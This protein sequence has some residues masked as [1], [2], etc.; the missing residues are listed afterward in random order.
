MSKAVS[1][2][3]RNNISGRHTSRDSLRLSQLSCRLSQLS[4][5]LS[6]L[7]G[8]LSILLLRDTRNVSLLRE[9]VKCVHCRNALRASRNMRLFYYPF[10][11]RI[12]G[13][14]FTNTELINKYLY[15]SK[16]LQD[17]TGYYDYGF[18]QYEAQLGRWHVIDAMAER[19]LSE[20]PY[21]YVNNDPIS[22]TDFMGLT[23][24]ADI[25]SII[26]DLMNSPYGGTWTSGG[27]ITY[28]SSDNDAMSHALSN[29]FYDSSVY[30][31]GGGGSSRF[32]GR[33]R[34]NKNVSFSRFRYQR[35]FG[36]FLMQLKA[37]FSMKFDWEKKSRW[38]DL[39]F[40][41]LW[42]NY[43]SSSIEHIDPSTG[44]DIFSDHCAINVSEALEKSGVNLSSANY[45]KCWHCSG[46]GN[47]AI[48]AQE[49]ANYIL[50]KI[51]PVKLKGNNYESYVKGKTGIIFF[52]DYWQRNGETGRTGDHIDLW[53]KNEL[54]SIGFFL[55]L[56]R[57]WFPETSEEYFDMSDLRKSKEVWFWEID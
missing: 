35:G 44:K 31:P 5:R 20:S 49:L 55:T 29:G 30:T 42:D 48:R 51:K 56:I 28:F 53:N 26:N 22:Y 47:H 40:D 15:N 57:G 41:K 19:F 13:Q 10:G 24:W 8:T 6:Q 11:M 38:D 12:N 21:A 34:I 17:Q 4:C 2:K 18:R 3:T 46:S 45:T 39:T 37:W 16:E 9:N 27:G 23:T 32:G 7:S 54:A 25:N 43:P 1:N 50:I 52:Q 14:H 33:L 36:G